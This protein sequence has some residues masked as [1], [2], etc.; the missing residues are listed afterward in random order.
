MA[1]ANNPDAVTVNCV[2][3]LDHPLS[4][5]MHVLDFQTTIINQLPKV[6]SITG[7]SS[8][9]RGDNRVPLFNHFADYMRFLIVYQVSVKLAVSHYQQRQLPPAAALT[10]HERQGRHNYIITARR[11]GDP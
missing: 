11:G 2:M 9:V 1:P 6:G 4:S 10:R 8:V 7:A 5:R 3:V